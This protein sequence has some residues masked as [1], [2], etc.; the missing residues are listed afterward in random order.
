MVSRRP[1]WVLF[2]KRPIL[3]SGAMLGPRKELFSSDMLGTG[4]DCF[5]YPTLGNMPLSS[6]AHSIDGPRVGPPHEPRQ[7]AHILS[8]NGT[9]LTS[10]RLEELC[11]WLHPQLVQIVSLQETRWSGQ[12]EWVNSEWSFISDGGDPHNSTGILLMIRR[13]FCDQSHISW[14]SWI[15]GRLLHVRLFLADRPLDI[16]CIYRHAFHATY[17]C[18]QARLHLFDQL[19]QL[20]NSI[21]S[22]NNL[23]VIGDFNTSLTACPNHIGTSSFLGRDGIRTTQ[24]P[25][26]GRLTDIVRSHGICM[27]NTWQDCLPPTFLASKGQGSRIDFIGT[28]LRQADLE[29]KQCSPLESCPLRGLS[30]QGHLPLLGSVP[31]KWKP[32]GGPA[33]HTVTYA[34]RVKC[35][36]EWRD[37][38]NTWQSFV[39]DTN[40]LFAETRWPQDGN[41]EELHTALVDRFRD[42]FAAASKSKTLW[43]GNAG[44][45]AQKWALFKQLRCV[46]G[47]RVQD[48]FHGWFMVMKHE[49]LKRSL[50]QATAHARQ[51]RVDTIID[52]AAQ[53]ACRH[54]LF[55]LH[56]LV[57]QLLPKTRPVRLQLRGPGG[58]LLNPLEEFI[59]IK[60]FVETRWAGSRL[61]TT[62]TIAPGVPFET[63]ELA[64][65]LEHLSCL[66]STAPGTMPHMSLKCSAWTVSHQIMPLLHQWWAMT[67]PFIPAGW[68]NAHLFLLP[69][70]SKPATEAGNLRPLA[71][72][73]ALGKTIL[74]VISAK[75][76]ESVL[77]VLT[78][79][80][81]FAYLPKRGTQ[82]AILRAAHHC[83]EV[84]Q[85]LHQYRRPS[86]RS[87]DGTVPKLYG[88]FTLSLNLQR[89]FDTI[90]RDF[91]F[92]QLEKLA[93]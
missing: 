23:I 3:L 28:R 16:V 66:K 82:D 90:P 6:P 71:L 21:P 73:D 63:W 68:K 31:L 44:P 62:T 26:S 57:N 1:V 83:F 79:Y 75:A 53:A 11:H 84:R 86:T 48:C 7:R 27:L 76:R 50:K 89:A 8:W 36:G 77:P 32:W 12:R 18:K 35:R 4:E 41:F 19:E 42:T 55:T 51:H 47:R 22:R 46:R 2:P 69:K 13:K 64:T 24:H 14:C 70:P 25:D 34:Q 91:L 58:Q 78:Q 17:T 65:A 40:K 87:Q 85:L 60:H 93:V 72:Q 30:E 52:E 45:S 10:A 38:S 9:G 49:S 37:H 29:A 88:G 43:D 39:Q 54:D 80:P 20:L 56:K 67:P 81:Q 92:N 74:G 59:H 33:L 5:P 61:E 15:R